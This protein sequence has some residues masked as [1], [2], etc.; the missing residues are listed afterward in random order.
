[1]DGKDKTFFFLNYEGTRRRTGNNVQLASV[2]TDLE[3]QGDFTQSVLDRGIPVQIF[4][5]RTSRT[6]GS[7]VR[8][9]PFPGN[10]VPQARFNDLSK[11]FLRYDP[12]ANRP[13]LPGSNNEGNFIGS[14]SSP[15]DNN[16]WTGRLD[17]NWNSANS[18]HGSVSYFDS[19]GGS[20]RWFS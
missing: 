5:P 13:P 1:Y 15:Y 12:Q 2:P 4:D 7:R 20:Q 18:T 14:A 19:F 3:R 6:E 10:R 11:I 16:R 8:R 9:N 17:H